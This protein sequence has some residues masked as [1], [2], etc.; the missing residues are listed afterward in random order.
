ML[1]I[2]DCIT[3]LHLALQ[4]DKGINAAGQLGVLY[5]SKVSGVSE[6]SKVDIN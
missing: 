2:H 4:H 3:T 6:V 5:V 1:N